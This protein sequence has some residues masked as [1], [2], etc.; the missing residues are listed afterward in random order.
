[1]ERR[2]TKKLTYFRPSIF[3]QINHQSQVYQPTIAILFS[4]SIIAICTSM[5]LFQ[6]TIVKCMNFW[7]CFQSNSNW[8]FHKISSHR[9][10]LTPYS[11][12]CHLF[13][14]FGLFLWCFF[15]VKLDKDWL[16][17]SSHLIE[18]SVN[19]IGFIYQWKFNECYQQLWSIH[20]NHLNWCAL[21]VQ[22]A[23]VKHSKELVFDKETYSKPIELSKFQWLNNN[24]RLLTVDTRFLWCYANF[25]AEKHFTQISFK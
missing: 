3:R 18:N 13:M 5:L 22:H 4:G 15:H 9:R 25:T 2:K 6:V 7:F 8:T 24:F 21:E 17:N 14:V 20:K 12:W 11:F 19:W 16:M 1:M 10:K 23:A